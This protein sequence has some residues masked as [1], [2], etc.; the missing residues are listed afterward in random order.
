[1]LEGASADR[2][3]VIHRLLVLTALAC[4]VL[5]AASFMMFA[6]DQVAGASKHQQRLLAV[7]APESPG[8][9][10]TTTRHGQPRR[11]ID[12]AARA[13]TSPFRGVVPSDSEWVLHIVPTLIGLL[14]YGVGLGYLA[15]FS[16]GFAHGPHGHGDPL[17]A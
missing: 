7:G 3:D 14:V 6:R 10:P 2:A 13:L 5:L 4:S 9:E 1:M 17:G 8:V 12:G 11:F 15:R 16:R